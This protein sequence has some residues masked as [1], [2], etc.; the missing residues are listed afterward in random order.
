M[1]PEEPEAG[2]GSFRIL[3]IPF[4]NRVPLQTITQ[5]TAAV[6][7]VAAYGIRVFVQE[8]DYIPFSLTLRLHTDRVPASEIDGMRQRVE[9]AVRSY[10]GDLRP[11]ERFVPNRLRSVALATERDVLDVSILELCIGRKATLLAE[12]VLGEEEVLVPDGTMEDPVR[13]LA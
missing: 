10:V 1:F 12:H 13:I 11:G 7:T 8:P 5:V 6:T 4:G 3:L 9:N 2:A